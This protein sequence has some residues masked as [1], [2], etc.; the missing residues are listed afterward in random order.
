MPAGTDQVLVGCPLPT[1][2][3]LNNV[4]LECHLI[5]PEGHPYLDAATYGVSGFVCQLMDPDTPATYDAIWD[6]LIPKDVAVGAGV[7]DLDTG[8]VD[9]TEEFTMGQPDWS[10]IFEMN[11]MG[12]LEIFRR[13]KLLTLAVS[14]IG[15]EK[16]SAAADVYTPTDHFSTQ[17][18]RN[19]SVKAPSVVL[20][21]ASSP[22]TDTVQVGPETTPTE[23]EWGWLQYAEIALKEAFIY[24]L[25]LTEAGAESPY[26]EAATFLADIL[27]AAVVEEDAGA[28]ADVSWRVF[29]LATFDITVPGDFDQVTLS[30]E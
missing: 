24:L 19:V 16:V 6:Q 22:I 14:S 18:K 13:R 1:G 11:A 4:W 26:E 17:V 27:E 25:G 3:K 10:G 20:F 15:Y 8:A 2:G 29:T 5:A 7:F 30:S 28:F 23:T 12:P 21:G 9:T